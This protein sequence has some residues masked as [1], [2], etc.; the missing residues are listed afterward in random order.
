MNTINKND[1][2][3]FTIGQV[4][5]LTGVGRS[6]IRHWEREF[7][8]FLSTARTKG[9]QRRFSPETIE[10][11]ERIKVLIREH[12]LT[13]RGVRQKLEEIERNNQKAA[14]EPSDSQVAPD[15][16]IKNLA[17]LMAEHIARQLFENG[18]KKK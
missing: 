3:K 18:G 7:F 8:D 2:V 5:A 6:T 10:K 9:N 17:E 1:G 16:K 15:T 12:G 11:I 4:T 13:L 14:E